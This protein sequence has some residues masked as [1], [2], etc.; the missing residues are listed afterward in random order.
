MEKYRLYLSGYVNEDGSI[1][2]P[3]FGREMHDTLEGALTEYTEG[4]FNSGWTVIRYVWEEIS[5]GIGDW[6][7][8]EDWEFLDEPQVGSYCLAYYWKD[9]GGKEREIDS[10]YAKVVSMGPNYSTCRLWGQQVFDP[11]KRSIL[12]HDVCVGDLQPFFY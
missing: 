8:D 4:S 10:Y 9:N 11:D 1:R 2:D 12:I 3:R 6:T 7:I 5:N